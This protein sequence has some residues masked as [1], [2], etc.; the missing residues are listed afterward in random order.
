MNYAI[1]T[2]LF[3]YFELGILLYGIGKF[4]FWKAVC[5]A[6]FFKIGKLISEVIKCDS[7][8]FIA[9]VLL[10]FSVLP[11]IYN[12]N[13]II[14]CI[15][16]IFIEIT[17][18]WSRKFFKRREKTSKKHKVISRIL[19][20]MFAPIFSLW[21]FSVI[22]IWWILLYR[23]EEKKW[24]VY[25][26]LIPLFD[27]NNK[28]YYAILF[29]HHMHYF[30]Y[31]YMI[32][33]LLVVQMGIP[34]LWVGVLFFVGW[35]AYNLY[36]GRVN[37]KPQ[38]IAWGHLISSLGI[39]IIWIFQFNIYM[40]MLGWF[41]TGLGGGTFYMIKFNLSEENDGELVE[42]YAQF[43]GTVLFFVIFTFFALDFIFIFATLFAIIVVVLSV[44]VIYKG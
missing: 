22:A 10:C 27:E 25:R 29:F 15:S 39:M 7:I 24:L 30:M 37:P 26:K 4:G 11:A 32:P 38:Y 41:L 6:I 17:L 40:V 42:L 5:I 2:F 35:G 1:G 18:V 28:L 34:Y 13:Y 16:S 33:Y 36:D 31:C 23:E 3:N 19:G 8:R 43:L 20:F 44:R 9:L 21:L 14:M 12:D